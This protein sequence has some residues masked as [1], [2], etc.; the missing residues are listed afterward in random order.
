MNISPTNP[1]KIAD[2]TARSAGRSMPWVALFFFLLG[3]A[4]TAMWFEYGQNG[5]PGRNGTAVP[6]NS[7]EQMRH[8]NAPAPTA[9]KQSL[10]TP[11]ITNEIRRLIPNIAATTPEEAERIFHDDF[12]KQCAK[13]GTEMEAQINA[14]AQKVVQAQKSDSAVEL[15]AARKQLSQVQ[16]AQTEKLK[17]VA[18]HFQLQ[19]AAFQQMKAAATNTVK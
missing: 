7:L 1:S 8:S 11:A 12:M 9:A 4:L 14:A 3:V 13:A 16:F 15:A 5:S 18:A 6:T 19:L 2:P 10:L 17:E